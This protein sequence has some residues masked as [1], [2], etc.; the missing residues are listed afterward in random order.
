MALSD[1]KEGYTSIAAPSSVSTLPPTQSLPIPPSKIFQLPTLTQIQPN[2]DI[3]KATPL[4]IW[5][6]GTFMIKDAPEVENEKTREGRRRAFNII[7]LSLVA[8]L[9]LVGAFALG[10][11]VIVAAVMG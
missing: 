11:F 10:S 3:E 5:T 6:Y 7:V 8:S 9:S 4:K 1:S 2:L